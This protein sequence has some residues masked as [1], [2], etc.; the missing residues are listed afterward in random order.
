MRIAYLAADPEAPSARHDVEVWR[1]EGAWV[2][3][4]AA[5]DRPRPGPIAPLARLRAAPIRLAEAARLAVGLCGAARAP[6]RLAE[7]C[8]LARL[9]VA[10]GVDAV[11]AEVADEGGDATPLLAAGL[12]GVPYGCGLPAAVALDRRPALQRARLAAAAWVACPTASVRD[13]AARIAP[14]A[15]PRLHLV[16]RQDPRPARLRGES[17][18][19]LHVIRE[20]ALGRRPGVRP[21]GAPLLPRPERRRLCLITP[22]RDEAELARRTLDSVVGQ[23]LPPTLWVI[24]DDGSTDETPAILAEYA[25]RYPLI[26]VVRRDDRGGRSV[27]PGVIDAFYAG[28]ATVDPGSFDYVCKLDLDLDLPPRYFETLVER[29]E[30]DP[31]LG[32]CSGKAYF[33]GPSNV[34]KGWD[35]ELIS[36]ACGD[37]TSVG[38]IKLY[39]R[40][41]FAAIGGFV[42]E[43]MWDGIDCHR[44]RQLGWK[45]RSWDDPEL[46]FLHLRPMGSSHKS[47]WTGRVRHGFGQ[48]FMGTGPLYMAASALFRATRPPRITGGLA[49]AWGYLAAWLRRRPRYEDPAFRTFLRRYQ[50]SCLLRGKGA[51]TAALERHQAGAWRPG[52]ELAAPPMAPQRLEAAA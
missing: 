11:H 32:T 35:G 52:R 5:A 48:Y 40:E 8:A 26:R 13:R 45:A 19:L 30:L 18:W 21:G 7:A 17:R 6:R 1:E 36:E 37:E 14:H 33:P 4:L 27:G 12:A 51:A 49:M 24:V 23:T 10:R 42:R 15:A 41:C 43:V 34:H 16:R 39:R 50:R 31:R 47:L 25:R 9:L 28:Y 46:R 38:M 2:L 22:C 44:C 29:M 3:P 20:V